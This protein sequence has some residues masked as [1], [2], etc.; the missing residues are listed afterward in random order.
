MSGFVPQPDLQ[1]VMAICQLEMV[2]VVGLLAYIMVNFCY[3]RGMSKSLQII[4][5]RLLSISE[6][7]GTAVRLPVFTLPHHECLLPS[8]IK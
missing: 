6:Y 5:A 4:L 7:L 3:S 8:R 2:L 1:Y